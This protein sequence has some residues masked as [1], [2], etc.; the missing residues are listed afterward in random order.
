[1]LDQLEAAGSS[2]AGDPLPLA[3]AANADA[4]PPHLPLYYTPYGAL[5]PLPPGSSTDDAA[6]PAAS[7]NDELVATYDP[8]GVTVPTLLHW[9]NHAVLL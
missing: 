4:A 5:E 3:T 6:T 7:V 9:H 8:T 2:A 1:M